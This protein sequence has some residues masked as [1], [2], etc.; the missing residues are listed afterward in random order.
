MEEAWDHSTS[1]INT[2]KNPGD[3]IF[4]DLQSA[5]DGQICTT[6]K[7]LLQ[8]K[9]AVPNLPDYVQSSQLKWWR[10]QPSALHP[11]SSS[12]DHFIDF[13]PSSSF[14]FLERE[15]DFWEPALLPRL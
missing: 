3:Q 6:F 1:L 10:A 11:N 4:V 12:D 8:P 9:R 13:A 14:D 15:E 2:I 5:C 7:M